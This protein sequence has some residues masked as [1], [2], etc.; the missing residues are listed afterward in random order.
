MEKKLGTLCKVTDL[1]E[2]W[3]HEALSFTPWL[4]EEPNIALLAEAIGLDIVVDETESSVG[5]FSVDI[6]AHEVGTDRIIIIENQ[7]ETG[8]N[9]NYCN[10]IFPCHAIRE[11]WFTNWS[12]FLD[13]AA[14]HDRF[15]IAGR[16][17]A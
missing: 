12:C 6:L 17:A 13:Y 16:Y 11:Y 9:C 8:I 14:F 10:C 3:P 2:Y 1:R 15:S 4:A 5:S 7:L